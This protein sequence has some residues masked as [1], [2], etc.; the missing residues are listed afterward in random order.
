MVNHVSSWEKLGRLVR[1]DGT[2]PWMHGFTGAGAMVSQGEE[3][4]VDLY[5]TG[6][7]DQNRSMIGRTRL[8]L[9]KATI[10]EIEREPVL[11]PGDL[12][13]FDENGV[14]YPSLVRCGEDL[15]MFYT[16]WMP[17]VLTPFQNHLGLAKLGDDGRFH[18]VS[19][20]PVL[21]RTNED[22]LSIGSSYATIED[23]VW[24]LWY[25]SFIKW[26]T[27]PGVP[28]HHYEIKYAQSP[29]GRTW[30]RRGDEVCIGA[31]NV[32]EHS[33]CRPSVLKIQGR[34]HMWYCHRGER[35]RIGYASS[36]DGIAW[37]RADDAVG[38]E[39]SG[40]GW[41]SDEQGYPNVIRHGEWLYMVYSGNGFGKD[42]I[43]LARLPLSS[44]AA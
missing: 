8:D 1:A 43:G 22:Y 28:K 5:I 14:S 33:L 40:Q 16:G 25:T 11:T 41:D 42:G 19:R 27:E 30:T 2:I 3:P 20:A 44:F 6:R 17:S 10:L 26:G 23:G 31:M 32:E 39:P 7:D 4:V 13:A 21:P 12:G 37:A 9:E 34:Y 38:I 24:R 36:D 29:D 35:Y 15:F 18:R